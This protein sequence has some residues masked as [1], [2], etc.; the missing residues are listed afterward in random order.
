MASPFQKRLSYQRDW[1]NDF[2]LPFLWKIYFEPRNGGK[3]STIGKNITKVL[4]KYERRTNIQWPVDTER[5]DSLTDKSDGFLYAASVAF[6][7][8]IFDIQTMEV[9][10]I[11][12]LINGYIGGDRGN[13]GTQ[14]KL[15]ITFSV[16]NIDVI[17][18][19]IR[20]WVL[21]VSHKGLIE[22]GAG[23][24]EDLKCNITIDLHTRDVSTYNQEFNF[25]D[26]KNLTMSRRKRFVFY[27]AVPFNT[28]GKDISYGDF[29]TEDIKHTASFAFSHYT[30]QRI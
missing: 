30:T 1:A 7:S 17:D 22:M 6:P 25:N 11:G 26:T 23:D 28:N 5:L 2:P 19:F 27:N 15:D 24:S 29:S 9:K 10:N 4:G 12:G 18:Y 3:M 20:P 16:T 13:Y 14:N 21:A 8:D